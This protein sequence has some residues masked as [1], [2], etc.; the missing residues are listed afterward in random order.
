MLKPLMLDNICAVQAEAMDTEEVPLE[1]TREL[2]V[3]LCEFDLSEHAKETGYDFL[4]VVQMYLK[5]E[6]KKK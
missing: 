6:L 4:A 5:S 1:D 2:L 3:G